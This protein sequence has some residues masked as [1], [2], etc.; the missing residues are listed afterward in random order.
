MLKMNRIN[1]IV[2]FLINGQRFAIRLSEIKQII[3]AVEITPIPN[4]PGDICGV[5]DMHG[6]IIPVINLHVRIGCADRPT[7]V[8]DRFI[9]AVASHRVVAL[10]VDSILDIISNADDHFLAGETIS[11]DLE[12]LG[13]IRSNDGIILIYDL[14][15][16]L[17]TEE[18][19]F[20]DKLA[21]T[22]KVNANC[23]HPIW[24]KEKTEEN[25]W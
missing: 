1:Q 20:M 14:E 17:T 2:A 15:T 7:R 3:R 22:E 5:I 12:I 9:I 10:R 25:K 21:E 13:I 19:I 24:V 18:T 11:S 4:A 6:E 23:A 8:D 16:F